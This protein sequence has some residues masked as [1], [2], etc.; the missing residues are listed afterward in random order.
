MPARI[1]IAGK[2]QTIHADGHPIIDEHSE[3]AFRRNRGLR[4]S[5]GTRGWTDG[6]DK[7]KK[8]SK[9]KHQESSFCGKTKTHN[10]AF[11]NVSPHSAG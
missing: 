10:F 1:T 7:T 11:A 3:G 2:V 8:R 4:P 9:E 5:E 6:I